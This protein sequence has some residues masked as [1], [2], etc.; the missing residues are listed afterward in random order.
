MP[1][2]MFEARNKAALIDRLPD[3]WIGI[4]VPLFIKRP[5]KWFV[6]L[7]KVARLWKC[8]VGFLERTLIRAADRVNLAFEDVG[9]DLLHGRA[10][11]NLLN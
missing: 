8:H 9:A 4:Q 10:I 3:I 1:D 11:P 2:V 7:N 6:D 5:S